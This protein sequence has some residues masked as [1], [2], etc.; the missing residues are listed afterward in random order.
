MNCKSCNLD[1][2]FDEVVEQCIDYSQAGE[3]IRNAMD[4][5]ESP[6]NSCHKCGQNTF[7]H[8][9]GCCVACA[10]ELEYTSCEMCDEPLG[11][12]DPNALNI[13]L[14]YSRFVQC[15]SVNT[16]LISI[17]MATNFD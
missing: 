2:C 15:M 8:E 10:Y 13:P 11:L 4:G 17:G 16:V 3:A 14:G 5:G 12:E 7:I 6:Y 1:F 9:E